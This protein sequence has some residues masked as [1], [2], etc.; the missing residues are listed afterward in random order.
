[1]FLNSAAELMLLV[2][3][4][5]VKLSS[6]GMEDMMRV[7]HSSCKHDASLPSGKIFGLLVLESLGDRYSYYVG[8]GS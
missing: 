4:I 6:E 2:V 8:G 7:A 1:M 3:E 5:V